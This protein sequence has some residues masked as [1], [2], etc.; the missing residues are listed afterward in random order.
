MKKRGLL[1]L[2]GGICLALMLVALPFLGACAAPAPAETIKWKC[3]GTFPAI[4][5]HVDGIWLPLMD[6]VYEKTNG[7]LEI[8]LY[9]GGELGYP[10]N[11]M[12]RFL[13]D[14]EIPMAELLFPSMEG[15]FPLGNFCMLPFISEGA[16]DWTEVVLPIWEDV[17]REPL[18]KDWNAIAL[19]NFPFPPSHIFS[20]GEPLNSIEAFKGR[21]LRHYGGYMADI[22]KEVGASSTYMVSAEVYMAYQRGII[23]GGPTSWASAKAQRLPEVLEWCTECGMVIPQL[24]LGVNKDAFDALPGDVR[25]VLLEVVQEWQGKALG[26]NKAAEKE[27]KAYCVEHGI[28]V[29]Q[30]PPDV[31][32][33]L[34]EISEPMWAKWAEKAGPLGQEALD[35]LAK[36]RGK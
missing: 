17:T 20:Q 14:G 36:A 16:D 28:Q 27:A 9:P 10:P 21:T 29:V 3:P 25:K 8:T 5:W 12:L 24:T 15:E 33:E 11:E 35:R 32:Q 1:V 23:D 4:E 18:E 2:S 13:R 30:M 31:L 7:K 26:I 22:F 34:R 19:I 6:E